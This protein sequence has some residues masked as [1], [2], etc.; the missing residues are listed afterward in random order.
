MKILAYMILHQGRPYL[1]AAV[2]AIIDQVDYLI[3]FYSQ[4]PSQGFQT[5][6][7]CPDTGAELMAEVAPWAHKIAWI[8]GEWANESEHVN[9]VSAYV[10]GFDWLWRLDADEIA[11]PGMVA[12][13]IRQAKTTTK[14]IFRVPFVHFW[15]CFDRVCRDGSQPVRLINLRSGEGETTLDSL[16]QKW[17]VFHGGYAQ[18]SRYITYKMRV[19]GHRP[20]WRPEWYVE[21]WTTN[22][23]EN[24]HPVMH[25]NHWMPQDFDKTKLP[26]VLKRHPFYSMEVIE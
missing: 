4:K 17:E 24:T 14:K 2:E 7:P 18:P 20:E 8:S 10:N 26:D 11:P 6:I 12:E 21:V 15:R 19:S 3:I 25:T 23:Q 16:D 5:E 9:A 22:K 13:M 1:A